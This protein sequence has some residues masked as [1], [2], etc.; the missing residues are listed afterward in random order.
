M[1]GKVGSSRDIFACL[2]WLFIVAGLCDVGCAEEWATYRGDATRS[3]VSGENLG[4]ELCLQ[5]KYDVGYKPKPAWPLPAEE[6]P[7]MHYDSRPYVVG[8]EGKIYIRIIT[9]II[10]GICILIR[11]ISIISL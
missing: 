8:A 11:D 7:R 6:L 4:T 5:W 3:G 2:V 9:I 1:M 10:C